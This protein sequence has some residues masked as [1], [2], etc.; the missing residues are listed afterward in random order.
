MKKH[1]FT[2]TGIG[3]LPNNRPATYK[4]VTGSGKTNY[5][6]I[7]KRGRL[8]DRLSEHLGEIPGTTIKVEQHSTIKEARKKEHNAIQLEKPKYNNQK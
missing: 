5:I 6:G 2:K 8:Q 7:A 1:S 4:I 3:N